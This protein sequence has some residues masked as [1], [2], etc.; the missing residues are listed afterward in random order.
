MLDPEALRWLPPTCFL[1]PFPEY[2]ILELIAP[3]MENLIA[4]H[5]HSPTTF[6]R[7]F[8]QLTE[9]L[10]ALHLP[11]VS[12]ELL[13]SKAIIETR[14]RK[15]S[16]S[17]YQ[18]RKLIEKIHPRVAA[19]LQAKNLLKEIL[20]NQKIRTR[21]LELKEENS[22]LR[23]RLVKNPALLEAVRTKLLELKEEKDRV[24]WIIEWL[25][26]PSQ[27]TDDPE[28]ILERV[29]TWT[30][31]GLLESSWED[32][33]KWLEEQ[34]LQILG[35]SIE[36]PDHRLIT[37]SLVIGKF[38]PHLQRFLAAAEQAIARRQEHFVFTLAPIPHLDQ[39][40]MLH[41]T[42]FRRL[43]YTGEATFDQ[44]YAFQLTRQLLHYLTHTANLLRNYQERKSFT[45][46]IQLNPDT[47]A[48][49]FLAGE[50]MKLFSQAAALYAVKFALLNPLS[51]IITL[52]LWMR[53][54]YLPE[55]LETLQLETLQ[56]ATAAPLREHDEDILKLLEIFQRSTTSIPWV[57]NLRIGYPDPL[58]PSIQRTHTI[59]FFLIF[60]EKPIWIETPGQLTNSLFLDNYCQRLFLLDLRDYRHHFCPLLSCYGFTI[61]PSFR[62]APLVSSLRSLPQWNSE[63]YG[64]K[65][66]WGAK[67][68]FSSYQREYEDTNVRSLP[69][70]R[71]CTPAV[72]PE[73]FLK[74]LNSLNFYHEHPLVS[75]L[76]QAMSD[77]MLR[78]DSAGDL[79]HPV[80]KIL[81]GL[82]DVSSSDFLEANQA[83]RKKFKELLRQAIDAMALRGYFKIAK[84]TT[85]YIDRKRFDDCTDDYIDDFIGIDDL[86]GDDDATGD[87]DLPDGNDLIGGIE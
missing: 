23:E 2:E 3:F 44:T 46:Q 82:S 15:S 83:Q 12:D 50:W 48:L 25:T 77:M 74:T 84:F 13:L 14:L 73:Q 58:R 63:L 80:V 11:D 29:H 17:D 64:Q 22:L 76:R 81:S 38:Y 7:F 70:L 33:Q 34:N 19:L 87:D 18:Q 68:P 16:I 56:S 66:R 4:P 41:L 43:D 65:R 24:S 78:R 8:T 28:T 32:L 37:A 42:G 45:F 27:P 60:D 85:W 55:L 20:A 53:N 52:I 30:S 59:D 62:S 26:D 54:Q 71:I 31:F 36:P 47:Q 10:T 35:G 49:L 75:T 79:P 72:L 9:K 57:R 39:D 61:A 86:T 69:H 21:F 67:M 51:M 40:H 5:L 6:R 1:E